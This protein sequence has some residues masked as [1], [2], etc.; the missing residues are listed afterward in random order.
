MSPVP[1]VRLGSYEILA[2]I[3]AGG[4]GEVY[5]ARD[6]KLNRDVALKILPEAFVQDPDRVARFRRE[7]HVLAALNHPNI[8]HIHGF[9]DSTGVPALV[10]EL[11]EGP[12]LADRIARGPMP[13]NE[14]LPIAKQIA[15]ALEAAH[16]QGIIHRDLKPA[17]IKVRDDGT[18]KVLDFGLA[19]AL[20]PTPASTASATMSPTLSIHATRAGIILGT[21]AYMSPEQARGTPVDKRS[22]IW[23]FGCVVYEMLAGKPAFTGDTLT[24]IVATVM[25]N[26]PDWPSVPSDTPAGVRSLLRRCLSKDPKRRLHDIADA[27][28]ELSDIV[29]APISDDAIGSRAG[30]RRQMWRE[31][32]AWVLALTAVLTGIML[33]LRGPSVLGR[34]DVI[35]LSILAPERT[36]FTVKSAASV[37]VPQLELSPDGRALVFAAAS[38]AGRP[39]LWLRLLD[40]MTAHPLPGTED[41][42]DPFWSPDNH[43]VGFFAGGK[44]KKSPVAGGPAQVIA[45]G[46]PDSRGA[47][48]ASDDTI[49]FSRGTSGLLRVSA[50]GGRITPVTE[51]DLSRQEGSHRFAQFLPDGKHFLF[52]VRSSL[53]DYWGVYVGSLDGKPRK[54]LMHGQT[55]AR[56]AV[57][58]L[59]FLDGD[60]MMAQAFNTER[61]ELQGEAYVVGEH[62]GRSSMGTAA[63]S[64]SNDGTLAYASTLSMPSRLAW[65]DRGGNAGGFVASIADYTD[66]RLSPDETRLAA[67]VADPKTGFPDVW[68]IDVARSISAPFTF[69]PA[70][71][72][73]ATWSPDGAR[74]VFRTTRSGGWNEFWSKSAGGGGKEEPVL[75][76]AV[77]RAVGMTSNTTFSDWSPDGRYLLFSAIT[78]SDPDWNLWITPVNGDSK[79]IR[80]LSAPGDQWHG[81]FSPDGHLVA[82]SSSESGRFE[83]HVQTFPLSDRQWTVSAEGGYEP[84]WRADGRELY[85]LSADQKLMAVPVGPGPSFGSPKALFQTTVRAGVSP[86]RTHYVPSRDGQRFLIAAPVGEQAPTMSITVVL[87]AT[88]VLKK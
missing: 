62:V 77:E 84:R 67:S 87:N 86:Q 58:H 69:G 73:A 68:M 66:F 72:A 78:S 63:Y 76:E 61:L 44:L 42:E 20:D 74:I 6:T 3:G 64:L 25:K 75:T 36:S 9:E 60:T 28:I 29:T 14:A 79:P 26:E 49:L 13:F 43:W 71:N 81:N 46:I 85:Y 41:A 48:W 31:R 34:T 23:A 15:E 40:S 18:V 35:R 50:S 52:Q 7:A 19:K 88:A 51:L 30:R 39:T 80:F 22:D 53:P 24:D 11:V 82:Y 54:L 45:S 5:R 47:S 37:G 10:M 55:T 65:F 2:A 8:A 59:F 38:P 1:G 32:L 16:E 27:R 17:N 4:M 56:Y 70:I 57:G 21:A 83:V 33:W 12:T